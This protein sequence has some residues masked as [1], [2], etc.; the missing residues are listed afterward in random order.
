MLS[1]A[2]FAP[3]RYRKLMSG[4][5]EKAFDNLNQTPNRNERGD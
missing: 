4:S 3:A 5:P 1:L 2:I